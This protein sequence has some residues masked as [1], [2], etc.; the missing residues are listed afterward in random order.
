M[1]STLTAIVALFSASAM[2]AIVPQA[3]EV[4]N[5]SENID[6][7]DLSVRK[8]QN[9]T[10]T[11]I[12]F[13]LSGSETTDLACQGATDVPSGVINCG[14]SMYRFAIQAGT[15]SEFALRIYHQLSLA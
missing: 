8:Q 12:S 10:V 13:T 7:A 15:E 3:S 5:P 9:G 2:A 11:S 14:D 1:K 4:L 6:I